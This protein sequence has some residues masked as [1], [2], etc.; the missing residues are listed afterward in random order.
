MLCLLHKVLSQ[1]CSSHSTMVIESDP[2]CDPHCI[3]Q[4]EDDFRR[5]TLE[6]ILP[7]K[8]PDPSTQQPHA[9]FR[10]PPELL[11]TISAAVCHADFHK[12]HSDKNRHNK[13]TAFTLGQ[14]C[15]EWRDIVWST[16][17]IWS[18][19]FLCLSLTR[20]D[21]QVKLLEGWLNRS[22]VCPLS[23]S[24]IFQDEED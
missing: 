4:L 21:A 14:I 2:P 9:I 16:P 11:G 12:S 5:L 19:V 15:R 23:L 3:Q 8:S 24:F 22:G 13:T 7:E 20:Y 10:L 1:L 17:E 18:H 6:S